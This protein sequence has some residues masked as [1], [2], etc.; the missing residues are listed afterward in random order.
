[1]ISYFSLKTVFLMLTSQAEE[2]YYLLDLKVLLP[3]N[4]VLPTENSDN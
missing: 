4:I 3:Q 1:M 2:F